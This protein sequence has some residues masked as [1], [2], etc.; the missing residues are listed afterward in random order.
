MKHL[1][2]QVIAIGLAIVLMAVAAFFGL[3]NHSGSSNGV[4]HSNLTFKDSIRLKTTPVKN[5]GRSELCW[6]YAMLS[7]IETNRL[8]LGD[9]V[10]LSIAYLSHMFLV[11]K[12]TEYYMSRGKKPI[13]SRG[14]MPMTLH[15]LEQYG[16][17][18]YQSYQGNADINYRVLTRKL[19]QNA[20]AAHG[21]R[22]SIERLKKS[23]H[24]ILDKEIGFMPQ[25]VFML[26]TEYT[27]QEFG[28]SIYLPGQFENLTSF[29]HHPFGER[30]ALEV[31]DNQMHD[32]FLNVPINTLMSRI[33][34][35]LRHGKAV[36]WEGD[37]SEEGF[38]FADGV[39]LTKEERGEKKGQCPIANAQQLRQKEFESFKTTD[40]HCMSLIGIAHDQYGR[41]YYIAKNSWGTGNRYGGYMYLSENYIRLKTIAVC[42]AL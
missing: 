6:I 11:Q 30:F 42:L 32:T 28:H 10:N 9:S 38:S 34:N 29:T 8:G 13:S 22:E 17:E 23:T 16:A 2:H 26:G 18:S 20:D 3:K 5:Q 1:K 39:A 36:C 4:A 41:R 21:K 25:F 24:D 27:P 40:D 35:S 31:P 37:T 14:M 15:L 12:T 19:M 33:D 7:T